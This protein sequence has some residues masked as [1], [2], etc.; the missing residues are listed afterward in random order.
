MNKSLISLLVL[1]AKFKE[2]SY[3]RFWTIY[4][5][6]KKKD[7][8]V[9]PPN[10]GKR[11]NVFGISLSQLGAIY[12]KAGPHHQFV[13]SKYLLNNERKIRFLMVSC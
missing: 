13:D 1:R 9:I 6:A 10:H 11:G 8:Y 2:I 3:R 12:Q 4:R 5:K 7:C